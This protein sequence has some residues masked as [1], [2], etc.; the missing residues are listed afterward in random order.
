MP[1]MKR[2]FTGGKMNKDLDERLIPNGEYRDAMNIQ[3]STSEESDVGTVQNILGNVPGC[4]YV[5][6]T[7]NPIVEGSTTVGS[8]SDEKNDSLY[9]FVAGPEISISNIILDLGETLSL[10]D[11]IMRT[12]NDIGSG[13]EP[14][15]V[16]KHTF[17]TGY[18]NTDSSTLSD[19]LYIDDVSLYPNILIGMSVTGFDANGDIVWG[20]G[21]VLVNQVGTISTIP[22]DY[23]VATT[24]TTSQISDPSGMAFLRTFDN[25]GTNDPFVDWHVDNWFSG[26][27]DGNQQNLPPVTSVVS[28]PV[29]IQIIL[30]TLP[31]AWQVGAVVEDLGQTNGFLIKQT[32]GSGGG[33]ATITNIVYDF[34]CSNG[35]HIDPNNY[36]ASCLQAYI[37]TLKKKISSKFNFAWINNSANQNTSMQAWGGVNENGETGQYIP[38]SNLQA[39]VDIDTVNLTNTMLIDSYSDQWLN[40]IYNALWIDTVTPTGNVLSI[41]ETFGSSGVW[42][43][44]SCIDPDSVIDAVNFDPDNGV[45]DNSINIVAC[46]LSNGTVDAS[47]L[48]TAVSQNNTFQPVQFDISYPSSLDAVFLNQAVE[49]SNT[50]AVCFQA[51]K[52]LNFNSS[53]L[54]T[55]V[56]IIDDML[57]WTDNF[58][59]PKKINIPR[60]VQGTDPSGNIH[61]NIINASTGVN[62]PAKEEHV[63]V[64]R[65]G[66]KSTLSVDL[67][68]SRDPEKNYSG[69]M[70]IST[71]T[72]FTDSTL[73][74]QRTDAAFP[75]LTGDPTLPFDFS[76]F[77]TEEGNNIFRTQVVSDLDGNTTFDLDG[78][79]IGSKVVLREFDS[80]GVPP[81]IPIN[82]YTIKGTIVP[83]EYTNPST[84]V[85]TDANSFTSDTANVWGAKLAIKITSMP[86]PPPIVPAGVNTLDYA[87]DLYDEDE[88]LFEFKFPRF[89]YRY[90][91]EDGEYSTFAPWT[92][93]AFLPS[94]FDYH[95][96]KGYNLA[97]VN[98]INHLYLRDFVTADMPSDVVEIDLLYKE[99]LSPNVYVI[100][101]LKPNSEA[102][103]PDADGNM[104]NNWSLN[105]FLID[106]ENIKSILPS[107]QLL[108]PWDNVPVKA[109]AQEVSG[110]RIIYGNYQQNYD[111]TVNDNEFNPKF[112]HSL[113]RNKQSSSILSIKSLREYQLGVVFTDKYGR[114]TPVI[115]NNTGTF[116]VDKSNAGLNNNLEISI[117]NNDIPDDMEYFK[118]YI[119]ETSGEYYNMAMDRYWDADDG[120]LWI[121]FASS[122]RNKIDIDSFLILKKGLG[123]ANLVDQKAKF[124]VIAIENEAPDFIKTTKAIVSD[125][126]HTSGTPDSNVFA[127]GINRPSEGQKE[128]TLSYY[129]GANDAHVYSNSAIKNLHKELN[130]RGDREDFYFQIQNSDGTRVST[131]RKIIRLDVSDDN[132]NNSDGNNAVTNEEVVWN[133]VL[134]KSFDSTINQFTNDITGINA[135]K[136]LNDNR[137]VFWRYRV[138]DSSIFDGRFFVKIFE[139]SAFTEHVKE[140]V[141]DG[142]TV[143]AV[144][145]DQKIYSFNKANHNKAWGAGGASGTI[146]GGSSS[147]SVTQNNYGNNPKFEHYIQATEW[148]G[149]NLGNGVSNSSITGDDWKS[150]SAFFRGINIHKGKE[151]GTPD[152]GS[153]GI[154]LRKAFESMD[155]HN[156]PSPPENWEF[157]DVWFIDGETSQ[158]SFINHWSG[159]P[160]NSVYTAQGLSDFIL[161]LG[162]GGIQ[163][164]EDSDGGWAWNADG[165]ISASNFGNGLN[166]DPD[167]LNLNLNNRYNTSNT[168]LGLYQHLKPNTVFRWKEDPTKTIYK[169]TGF[170]NQKLTRHES[171]P[172]YAQY[173]EAVG[174][175][176]GTKPLY[177]DINYHTST[178]FRPDN[179]SRNYRLTYQNLTNPGVSM[180]NTWNPYTQAEITNG[181]VLQVTA[182]ANGLVD[183]NKIT[184]NTLLGTDQTSFGYGDEIIT[185]GMVWEDDSGNLAV[186]SNITDATLTFKNYDPTKPDTTFD[187]TGVA[188]ATINLYQYG[189][190]GISRNSVKNIDKWN[191][192]KGYDSTN[193]GVDAVGYTLEILEASET[194]PEFPRFPAVF[195]TEPKESKDLDLYYEITDNNPISLNSN[196]I[197]SILPLNSTINI[198]CVDS[199][200][201]NNGLLTDIY[202]AG[203]VSTNGDSIVVNALLPSGVVAG[204]LVFI[205]K[206]SGDTISLEILGV[207]Q[208]T[209]SPLRSILQLNP[210]LINQTL[211]SRWHNCYSFGNGVESNRIRDNF[212]LPFILNG[213]KASATLEQQY[214]QEIR[215]Y[216]LIYSGLYNSTSGINNLNQFI[217][218]EKITKDINP[219]YGSIQKLHSRDSDLVAL[220][221]DKILKILASKDAVFNADGE[222]GLTATENVLGQT[223]PFV[224]EYGISNNPESFASEAYRAYFSDKVRGAIIRL[225]KDGLT[226]ISDHGMKSWFKDNLKLN[227]T[228]IGSYDDEKD[229]YNITLKDTNKT[230]TFKENVRGWVS[231]KSFIPEHA[232][233]CA[234]SYYSFKDANL[235]KHHVKVLDSFNNEINRNTFYKPPSVMTPGFGFT[236][237]SVNVILNEAPSSMKSFY[238]INYEGSQS[239]IDE[240][241]TYQIPDFTSFIGFDADGQS[242]FTNFTSTM[243]DNEYYNLSESKGWYVEKIKT[244]QGEGSLNEFIEKEGKWFNYIKGVAGSTIGDGNVVVSGSPLLLDNEDI[245][246]QGLGVLIDAPAVMSTFGCTDPDAINYNAAAMIDNGSC[247]AAVPGCTDPTAP[248]YDASANTDDGSCIYMGCTDST[249]TNY[250]PTANTNNGSCTYPNVGCT[251]ATAF[252]YDASF[253]SSCDGTNPT[254]AIVPCVVD[255]NGNMQSGTNCCCTPVIDGCTDPLANNYVPNANTDDGTC[256]YIILGCTDVNSCTWDDQANTD[257]GSCT[258]CNDSNANNWDDTSNANDCDTYCL[259]CKEVTNLSTDVVTD[260]TITVTWDETFDGNAQVDYYRLQYRETGCG[261]FTSCGTIIDVLP[262]S[263]QGTIVQGISGLNAETSYDIRVKTRCVAGSSLL[264]PGYWTTSDWTS[265]IQVSTT[266][267]PIAGCMDINACNYD[268]NATTDNSSCDFL[269]CDGCTDSTYLEFCDTCYDATNNVVVPEGTGGPWMLDNQ[270]ACETLIVNGCTD[271]TALNYNSLAN[272]NDGS[273]T[274]PVYG[275]TNDETQRFDGGG[276]AALNYNSSATTPCNADGDGPGNNECCQYQMPQFVH[277]DHAIATGAYN[278]DAETPN[279]RVR[280]LMMV[281]MT[282]VPEIELSNSFV[283]YSNSGSP[284][285]PYFLNAANWIIDGTGAPYSAGDLVGFRASN[286]GTIAINP[287]NTYG[288][289]VNAT[290]TAQQSYT[291]SFIQPS[292]SA[293]INDGNNFVVDETYS[294][295]GLPVCTD[296]TACNYDTTGLYPDPYGLWSECVA[297]ETGCT[298]SAFLTYDSTVTCSDDSGCNNCLPPDLSGFTISGNTPINFD[299][300]F[301][302]TN[303]DFART[304]DATQTAPFYSGC[305]DAAGHESARIQY[306]IKYAGYSS[307][308]P[309]LD[310]PEEFNRKDCDFTPAQVALCPTPP[311]KA[312]Y[313]TFS[314][315]VIPAMSDWVGADQNSGTPV[316]DASQLNQIGTQWMFRAKAHCVAIDS[317]SLNPCSAS[318]WSSEVTLTVT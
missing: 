301:T 270:N 169:I 108:R 153:H 129:D 201:G 109:L 122:D 304:F 293:A 101:T 264:N 92:N 298:D 128:F 193:I 178:Y 278:T 68:T 244:D 237:S 149:N 110:S 256:T 249:A 274:Y 156:S 59:E 56:N 234:N 63:T 213:V 24:T 265:F 266:M 89:S 22:I 61:T 121:S 202:V 85:T 217:Q 50:T 258:Y 211:V 93:V 143:Y 182:D 315:G 168:A 37:V 28:N 73:W 285:G 243:Q 91:Y 286:Q 314:V 205:N 83:W 100:E 82:D 188:S 112:I 312:N 317:S 99:D 236:K 255:E 250:D 195:E 291:F 64:I 11:M 198:R 176:A 277:F 123:A 290:Q 303:G 31:P 133:V 71:I 289:D 46:D 239:K 254:G 171:N 180:A 70:R 191:D 106:K 19:T 69:I 223:I 208:T 248:N 119:K 40:E 221:E 297:F 206:P 51:E 140:S 268:V 287:N 17:C 150:H 146:L 147:Y 238:T 44:N 233:S 161:E 141:V 144:T 138:E 230:V 194:E 210:K 8:I 29:F 135:T 275:C 173:Y 132:W 38:L 7:D 200:V 134:E 66:P 185:V 16:D 183:G 12:N 175:P 192:A 113:R 105:E 79:K 197:S 253:T 52:V 27:Y 21:D 163:P 224:G 13:C 177:N 252:N 225:S 23:Q 124:K 288:T 246:F 5:P 276:I 87:I 97:M 115:S 294:I 157:E 49:I 241:T 55:G 65:K 260:Q 158:G 299:M 9:W 187:G 159:N 154:N 296:S 98:S 111:L 170:G 4:T 269:T 20:G 281:D 283:N 292:G 62:V 102:T 45:Y 267:A 148:V 103:I 127:T 240:F 229:E 118:F 60:S 57:F 34:V 165:T 72:N 257:D 160:T 130:Q 215:K 2:N 30:P 262:N 120:N 86:A 222:V 220:C 26:G 227:N 184:V 126:K 308:G 117:K 32:W 273:C 313:N 245:S 247:I 259:Y 39:T 280:T 139:E 142:D 311:A 53:R 3:V 310:L 305:H 1:D 88:K 181:K 74:D 218:A 41:N 15:F 261:S 207:T 199:S 203:N 189:M 179:Y 25:N 216:G 76:S 307:F 228:L 94:S 18:E 47:T 33:E 204:D 284:G 164:E 43:P 302:N 316:Y 226:P 145:H 58:S 80:T 96:K 137:A 116:K 309:W 271:D 131:P 295:S 81:S 78:L 209:T 95:P 107:N 174:A 104:F 35:N 306:R 77:T 155:V 251:D 152:Y 214:K 166:T 125:I 219:I 231:F 232:N 300:I 196:N 67:K 162:F 190:N 48:H 136:I 151:S 242:Q 75:S 272:V 42:P 186:I 167:F 90:K 10:K 172:D 6:L 36:G 54:I 14:V 84:L 318:A 279:E 282:G 235:W 212:N 114:E 263:T